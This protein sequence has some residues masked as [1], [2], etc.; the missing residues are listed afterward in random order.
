MNEHCF[1][2]NPMDHVNIFESLLPS[3]IWSLSERYHNENVKSGYQGWPDYCYLPIAVWGDICIQSD[4]ETFSLS[5]T[6]A[7][8]S[9]LGAW[10]NDLIV[11]RISDYVFDMASKT[12]LPKQ[13]PVDKI[14][15]FSKK[16]LYL[17]LPGEDFIQG[18]FIH[19]EYD[20]ERKKPELRLLLDTG[21]TLLPASVHLG[22]WSLNSGIDRSFPQCFPKVFMG[23]L[24]DM[25]YYFLEKIILTMLFVMEGALD[26]VVSHETPNARGSLAKLKKIGKKGGSI[27]KVKVCSVIPRMNNVA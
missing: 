8:I 7:I 5:N 21:D 4:I 17:E 19:I 23:E 25:Q 1:F 11:Y 13:L 27:K 18:C 12:K 26:V 10:K 22:D 6:T 24:I 3:C 16:G 2:Q 9:G 20:F 14:I 15:A